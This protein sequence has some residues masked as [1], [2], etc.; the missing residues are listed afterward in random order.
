MVYCAKYHVTYFTNITSFIYHKNLRKLT[1]RGIWRDQLVE[2]ATLDPRA[3][4]SSPMLSVA[5]T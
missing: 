2:H 3:G 5:I 1:T 4:S